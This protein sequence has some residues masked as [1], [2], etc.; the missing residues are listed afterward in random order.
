MLKNPGLALALAGALLFSPAAGRAQQVIGPGGGGG[1]GTVTTLSVATANGFAGTVANPTTTPAI[2]MQTSVTGLTLGNGT[3]LTAYGGTSCTNQFPRSLNASGAAT[4]ATVANTDLANS[5]MTLAG[6]SVALGGTQTFACAD[7]S[8]GATGCSTATGT[9]G[10]TIPLLNGA[11]TWSGVQTFTNGDLSLLGSSTGHTLLES[12][13]S[14]SSNNTLTL[15]T[16]ASD[17]LAGLGTVQTFSAAQTFGE[18]HGTTYAPTLTTNNYTAQASDCGKTL[19]FPTGTTPTLT[20]PNLNSSCTIIVVQNSATQFTP[21]A[22]SG[23]TLATNVNG[24]TKSK[25]QNA[26]LIFTI[27]VPSASAATWV[28]SGDGA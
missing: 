5:S 12:G 3:A 20:L 18:V 11:N 26:I 17:T 1:S 13:L 21:Q 9:S 22:A 8:N 23:G 24:N 6:H 16:T 15:P 14:G 7:L 4:C 28:W 10:A 19:L 2:T 27:T 25:A